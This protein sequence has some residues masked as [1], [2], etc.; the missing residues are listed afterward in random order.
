M[1]L[2][3]YYLYF[4]KNLSKQS[5]ATQKPKEMKQ[6]ENPLLQTEKPRE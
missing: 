3:L 6:N 2:F 5:F 1:F 4:P